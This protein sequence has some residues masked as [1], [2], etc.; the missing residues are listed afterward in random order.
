MFLSS[1]FQAELKSSLVL[2][3]AV[4][5]S[6]AAFSP[7]R[8]AAAAFSKWLRATCAARVA[9]AAAGAKLVG[10]LCQMYAK[11]T[12]E[13]A[14]DL[15]R[16]EWG[17]SKSRG[18]ASYNK[19]KQASD[20]F[21]TP[22]PSGGGGGGG[23]GAANRRQT[24]PFSSFTSPSSSSS[25]FSSSFSSQP[26][27]R[28][29]TA[30]SGGGGGSGS[31]IGG[32]RV[33]PLPPLRSSLPGTVRRAFARWSGVL[34]AEE[35]AALLER[36]V[37]LRKEGAKRWKEMSERVHGGGGATGGSGSGSLG[38]FGKQQSNIPRFQRR[39]SA[40]GAGRG[41]GTAAGG[42]MPPGFLDRPP[43]EY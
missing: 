10:A 4:L 40:G 12:D 39:S 8:L 5:K 29:G 26:S 32:G 13:L 9:H 2:L 41:G 15:F 11:K 42:S 23:G 20:N 34:P 7:K 31:D 3:E 1:T 27:R 6:A 14:S 16:A 33:S 18:K 22:S 17:S 21:F 24:S 37:R 25:S 36:E 43:Q 35:R 38:G 30:G 28:R 19:S